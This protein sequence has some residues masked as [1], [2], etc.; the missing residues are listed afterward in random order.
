M[1]G[2]YLI[3]QRV[4]I[5]VSTI[6]NQRYKNKHNIRSTRN[7][8]LSQYVWS[9]SYEIYQRYFGPVWYTEGPSK[10]DSVS[11]QESNFGVA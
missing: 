4:W 8:K 7:I 2:A 1:Y 5:S 10:T 9:Q 11:R 3:N 6:S